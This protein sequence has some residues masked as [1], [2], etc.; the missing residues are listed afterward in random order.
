VQEKAVDIGADERGS[1]PADPKHAG[2]WL[3][4]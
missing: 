4:L 3:Q 2:V 1:A